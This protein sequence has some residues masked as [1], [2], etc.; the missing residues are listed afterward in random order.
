MVI[1]GNHRVLLQIYRRV[2]QDSLPY[3]VIT[4]ERNQVNWSQN[5]QDSFNKL[6][7]LLTS[8]PILKVADL[9]KYFTV[10]VYASKQGL[11]GVLT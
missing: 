3:H 6:K 4:K 2:L 7:E 8:T 5:C 9:D 11:S 10:C 1:H